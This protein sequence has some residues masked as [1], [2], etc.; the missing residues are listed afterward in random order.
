MSDTL[1]KNERQTL[2]EMLRWKD[3]PYYWRE[4]SVA[5]LVRRGFAESFP[6]SPR[7]FRITPAGR[8]AYEALP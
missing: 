1:S 6:G 4:V 5:N 7:G 2:G 3:R 8:E